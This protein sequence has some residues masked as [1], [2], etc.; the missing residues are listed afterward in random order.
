MCSSIIATTIQNTYESRGSEINSLISLLG[1]EPAKIDH[2]IKL[3]VES[4][5]ILSEL[6]NLNERIQ[7]ISTPNRVVYSSYEYPFANN[8]KLN[9]GDKVEHPKFGFGT[10]TNIFNSNSEPEKVE[11]VQIIFDD[12]QSRT[13]LASLS[14]LRK[15]EI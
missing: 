1:I 4:E 14:K 15:L 9:L 11:K 5:I 6:K 3:S 13:L 8:L 10:I 12:N 2:K 7:A